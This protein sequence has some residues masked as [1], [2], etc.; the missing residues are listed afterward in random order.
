MA[1][2]CTPSL[3][4]WR[5]S[6]WLALRRALARA[7]KL[8]LAALAATSIRAFGATQQLDATGFGFYSSAGGISRSSFLT[9]IASPYGDET[10]G[11]L[12]FD[13]SA[14][15]AG[16]PLISA[17]LR[18]EN[19]RSENTSGGALDLRLYALPSTDAANFGRDAG[20]GPNQSS[21]AFIGSVSTPLAAQASISSGS[22][23]SF[24]ELTLN[25]AALADLNANRSDTFYAYGVRAML[26]DAQT[27]KPVQ[28][29]FGDGSLRAYL[30][31][32][33]AAAVPEPASALTIL[34]GLLVLVLVAAP[35]A[36]RR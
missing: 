21:F 23:A 29:A 8:S 2:A 31:V 33:Y 9:G 27:P 7:I 17:Q 18:V 34:A 3:R 11:F 20:S 22:V 10:R 4:L 32:E 13:L 26:A 25:A 12:V 15:P 14:L 24:V 35:R 19:L 5:A 36:K 1:R 16:E 30:V 28:F 6:V